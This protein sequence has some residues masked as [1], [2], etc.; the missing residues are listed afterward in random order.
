MQRLH[1]ASAG[2]AL[3]E[4]LTA[5]A[6]TGGLVK[7][8]PF[9]PEIVADYSIVFSPR[10][11]STLIFKPFIDHARREIRKMLPAHLVVRG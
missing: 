11:A 8:V 9:E 5:S 1:G 7:F 3:I 2:L 6:Y 4:P 10:M